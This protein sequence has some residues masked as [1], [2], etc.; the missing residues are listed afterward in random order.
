MFP[1]ALGAAVGMLCSSFSTAN[2][3]LSL[4]NPLAVRAG[5]SEPSCPARSLRA[6]KLQMKPRS[7]RPP[8]PQLNERRSRGRWSSRCPL[9]GRGDVLPLGLLADVEMP[10]VC[11]L[12]DNVKLCCVTVAGLGFQKVSQNLERWDRR[13]CNKPA[14]NREWDYNPNPGDLSWGSRETVL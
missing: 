1:P 3:S 14:K 4:S 2:N 13:L 6:G 5:P 12:S 7:F 9:T 11:L 8:F 10:S